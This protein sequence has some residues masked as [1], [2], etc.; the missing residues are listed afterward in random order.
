[1]HMSEYF[2]D[3]SIA[4]KKPQH[5]TLIDQALLRDREKR[6]NRACASRLALASSSFLLSSSVSS[7]LE[8]SPSS[9]GPF[10]GF[11]GPLGVGVPCRVFF[12]G[13][14]AD[15]AAGVAG[16]GVVSG[17]FGV[18][19]AGVFCSVFGIS[20]DPASVFFSFEVERSSVLDLRNDSATSAPTDSALAALGRGSG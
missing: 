8:S 14:A 2:D 17:G 12:A 5:F 13:G 18:S 15:G 19:A 1:M 6:I 16:V 11:G 20:A 7:E 10:G 9:G 4:T 3:Y